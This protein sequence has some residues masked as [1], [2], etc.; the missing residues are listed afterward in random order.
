MIEVMNHREAYDQFL[1][2]DTM[3]VVYG[4]SSGG[5]PISSLIRSFK[6]VDNLTVEG[7][8][9][10]IF[11]LFN[12]YPSINQ[13]D[14]LRHGVK[15]G[16]QIKHYEK[17]FGNKPSNKLLTID[18][19]VISLLGLCDNKHVEPSVIE[20]KVK[21][22]LPKKEKKI[23]ERKEVKPKS[24][25][26]TMIQGMSLEEVI[27]WARKV[28]ISEDKIQHHSLKSLGLAKMNLANMIRAKVDVSKT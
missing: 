23:R 13:V 5:S 8:T 1:D 10:L 4:G 15:R 28:G 25:F 14:I 27:A 21:R 24:E 6:D 20:V 17:I 16:I 7:L 22:I 3:M 9:E 19:D 2:Y 26:S 12:K 11:L 18:E